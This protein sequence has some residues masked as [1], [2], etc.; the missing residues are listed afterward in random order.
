MIFIKK[1]QQEKPDPKLFGKVFTDVL[2]MYQNASILGGIDF[3]DLNTTTFKIFD[4]L[5]KYAG[6]QSSKDL[7]NYGSYPSLQCPTLCNHEI[8]T[9]QAMF[10]LSLVIFILSA[11]TISLYSI[12][13]RKQYDSLKERLKVLKYSANN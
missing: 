13:L 3:K 5:A 4:R 6:K 11:I 12:F 1:K 8:I 10:Y 2:N 9:W 7:I